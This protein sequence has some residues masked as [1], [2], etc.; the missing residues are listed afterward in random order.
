MPTAS[1]L[2]PIEEEEEKEVSDM[3]MWI[4][5]GVVA[6]TFVMTLFNLCVC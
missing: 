3:Q 6:L 5:L 2:E 4:S 1:S